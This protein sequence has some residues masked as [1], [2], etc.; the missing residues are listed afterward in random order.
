MDFSESES[1]V[2]SHSASESD[3]PNYDDM[4]ADFKARSTETKIGQWA[5]VRIL[6]KNNNKR[7]RT[8]STK[9]IA[10]KKNKKFDQ[11][12]VQ[13][14]LD[15]AFKKHTPY[16][17]E[18]MLGDA[19]CVRLKSPY[20]AVAGGDHSKIKAS[21]LVNPHT[22]FVMQSSC[23]SCHDKKVLLNP[24]K[25]PRKKTTKK[26]KKKQNKVSRETKAELT[27]ALQLSTQSPRRLII[28]DSSVRRGDGDDVYQLHVCGTWCPIIQRAHSDATHKDIV[29]D[30]ITT[31]DTTRV[32]VTC[33]VCKETVRLLE[34]TLP[35]DSF[36]TLVIGL[37]KAACKNQF[38]RKGD[39]VVRPHTKIP[40][41]FAEECKAEVF[42]NRS[43]LHIPEYNCTKP[44]MNPMLKWHNTVDHVDFPI[45][46]ADQ[47]SKRH[48]SFL[49]GYYDLFDDNFVRWEDLA[50]EPPLTNHFYEVDFNEALLAAPTP[51][52]DSLLRT[53]LSQESKEDTKFVIDKFEGLCGRLLLPCGFDNWQVE[54]FIKGEA[55]TGKSTIINFVSDWFPDG[56]VGSISSNHEATFG[57]QTLYD[58]RLIVMPDV[59]VGFSK[60]LEQ[61]QYQNMI[62]AD[63]VTVPRKGKDALH[64]KHWAVP[65]FGAGNMM[66]DYKD[67]AGQIA[68]RHAAFVF[69]TAV[70]KRDMSLPQKMRETEL[71]TVMLRCVKQYHSQRRRFTGCGGFWEHAGKYLNDVKRSVTVTANPVMDFLLNGDA[72]YQVIF[73]QSESAVVPFSKFKSIFEHYMNFS[74]KRRNFKLTDDHLQPLKL[75]GFKIKRLHVCKVCDKKAAKRVCG[76]HWEGGKNRKKLLVIQNMVLKD[77]TDLNE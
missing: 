49:N 60:V 29:Y 10:K 36:G 38:R 67:T 64:V 3:E 21:Y 8:T 44:W 30:I 34:Q 23:Y 40:G 66:P 41:V 25:K 47:M 9:K 18:K 7:K 50:G 32:D 15:K 37:S 65:V 73:D 1:E 77:N 17:F 28:I 46:R 51:L 70:T 52:W 31:G 59:G 26:Q 2:T 12:R 42:I 74:H 72:R 27:H 58:K 5:T 68:R 39:T 22:G 43:L 55:N 24:E 6:K 14:L 63:K 11:K 33:N 71:V 76:S 57:L 61:T 56:T 69:G 62:S 48:I 75:Q 4:A 54:L 16:T 35:T 13:E 45:I 53:Q 19:V 20:C